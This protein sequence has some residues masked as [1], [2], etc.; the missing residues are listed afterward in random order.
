MTAYK[1]FNDGTMSDYIPTDAEL[2]RSL[3][4]LPAI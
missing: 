2:Q 1:N 4:L 3:D